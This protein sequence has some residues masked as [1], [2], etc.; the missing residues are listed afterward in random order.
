MTVFAV[1]LPCRG[2]YFQEKEIW[3]LLAE[4]CQVDLPTLYLYAHAR[5]DFNSAAAVVPADAVLRCA[6]LCAVLCSAVCCAVCCDVCCA[7]LC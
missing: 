7:V 6:V 2:Q 4:I 5:L 3:G 1:D